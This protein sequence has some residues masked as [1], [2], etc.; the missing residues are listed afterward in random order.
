LQTPIDDLGKGSRDLI[1]FHYF[2][3]WRGRT[4]V[5]QITPIIMKWAENVE[6][7]SDYNHPD[8]NMR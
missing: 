6:N 1:L 8:V 2:V 5:D 3:V 7:H 4:D